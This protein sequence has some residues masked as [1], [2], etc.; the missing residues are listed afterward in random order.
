MSIRSILAAAAI[1]SLT[2]AAALAA[3]PTC[4]DL[5]AHDALALD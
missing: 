1:L 2:S 5:P 4:A 3:A